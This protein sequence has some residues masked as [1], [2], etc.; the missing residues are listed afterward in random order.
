MTAP[1]APRDKPIFRA[2]LA[3]GDVAPPLALKTAEGE[4]IDLGADAVIGNPLV[5][6]FWPR[7]DAAPVAAAV[8][9]MSAALSALSSLGARVFAVTLAQ[10]R[11]VAEQH[12]PMPVLLDRDGK[13][14]A[15]W[16]AG[17]REQPTTVV[18]RQN[19]HVTAILKGDPT[20]QAEGA[21]AAVRMLL[22]ERKTLVPTPHAPILVLP[23]VMSP[24][25]CRR[26]IQIYETRG[27]TFVEPG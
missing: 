20:A 6:V 13:A 4:I 14:F 9:S 5:V 23:E 21:V 18:L 8:A 26:L 27:K 2:P 11:E 17:T 3:A 24:E 1:T 25:D 16:S 7:F 19:G 15:A 10:P 22:E 12:L